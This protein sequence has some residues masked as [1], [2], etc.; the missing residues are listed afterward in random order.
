[1]CVPTRLSPSSHTMLQGA[2]GA[3][4]Q[5]LPTFLSL[6]LRRP[7]GAASGFA[8][9]ASHHLNPSPLVP[10]GSDGPLWRSKALQQHC[11][12]LLTYVAPTY[13]SYAK[14]NFVNAHSS[15]HSCTHHALDTLF[16]KCHE[17][18]KLEHNSVFSSNAE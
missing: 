13:N 4:L 15:G 6:L 11:G 5:T 14:L 10:W 16:H 1:M 18:M 7:P 3:P 17:A 9:S 8:G 2:P 12:M